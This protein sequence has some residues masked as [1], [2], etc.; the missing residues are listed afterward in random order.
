MPIAHA[1]FIDRR[2][3]G[4]FLIPL[5]SKWKD[6]GAVVFALPRGGVPAAVEIARALSLPLDLLY[7]RKIAAPLEPELALGAIVDGADPDIVFNEALVHKL[8]V[9]RVVLMELTKLELKEIER[10]RASYGTALTSPLMP[11]GRP[12]IIVDDGLATGATVRAAVKALRRRG[13]T[14]VIVAVPVAPPDAV[15]ALVA[16]GAE[17]VCPHVCE[18]FT[19]VGSFYHDFPQLTDNQ[20]IAS[21]EAFRREPA[22]KRNDPKHHA[23]T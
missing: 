4:R 19:S 2:D 8:G 18:P 22:E 13:A 23:Q 21:I 15:A 10:R 17:V 14:H 6:S 12:A 9:S 3:A 7:V 1:K 11:T 16:E 20:V 5:L